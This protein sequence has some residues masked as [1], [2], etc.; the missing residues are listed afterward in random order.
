MVQEAQE[1]RARV[2]ADLARRRRVLHSQIEQLRAGRERLAETISDVRQAVDQITDE[3]FRAEDE[4]RL[5]AEAAGRQAAQGELSDVTTTD[6]SSGDGGGRGAPASAGRR[7]RHE[8][9]GGGALRPAAGRD[10]RH[11][12]GRAGDGGRRAGRWPA[13]PAPSPAWPSPAWPSPAWPSLSRPSPSPMTRSRACASCRPRRPPMQPAA[14][15]PSPKPAIRAKTAADRAEK[16]G[17]GPTSAALGG[18]DAAP[19]A[20]APTV[21]AAPDTEPDVVEGRDPVLSQRDEVL[22]PLVV[23]LARRLKRALQDDQNDILDRLRAKGGWA[24]GV[25]LS[26]GRPRAALRRRRRRPVD[27]SGPGRRHLRGRQGR[28]GPRLSTTWPA[29]MAA[30]IVAP[31][32]RRLEDAGPSVEEGDESGAGRARRRSVSRVEGCTHR[33]ARRRPDGLRLRAGGAGGGT[34]RHVVALG[35]RRR[36]GGVPGL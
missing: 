3:L 15:T 21:P 7:T 18:A 22:T 32:R 11:D 34:R 24:P 28:R 10:G 2:L 23:A 8:A 16:P 6:V 30:E 35:G 14:A 9:V 26:R 33:T 19:G 17:P 1:L 20:D 5:A 27:R 12:R 13:R 36:R 25:L 31:L 29:S 4:A